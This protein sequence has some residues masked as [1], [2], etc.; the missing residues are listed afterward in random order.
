M[1]ALRADGYAAEVYGKERVKPF[2]KEVLMG[3]LMALPASMNIDAMGFETEP[4]KCL[5]QA[6]PGLWSITL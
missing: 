3:A 5:A 1:A 4:G 6:L 2:V